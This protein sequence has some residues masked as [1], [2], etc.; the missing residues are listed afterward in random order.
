MRE[1]ASCI[2]SNIIL[3]TR[4]AEIVR[5]MTDNE[6]ND[7]IQWATSYNWYWYL[8]RTPYRNKF[9]SNVFFSFFRNR[10][11]SHPL[12]LHKS[13]AVADEIILSRHAFYVATVSKYE[14]ECGRWKAIQNTIDAH[15]LFAWL[16]SPRKS[17]YTTISSRSSRSH[18]FSA[19]SSVQCSA[20]FY[21]LNAHFS[22]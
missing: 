6:A 21:L 19:F 12:R 20:Y 13:A 17:K 11:I 4:F 15:V 14:N 2:I 18:I 1:P 7:A 3:Q 8:D 10:A 9:R 5:T 22:C 16:I